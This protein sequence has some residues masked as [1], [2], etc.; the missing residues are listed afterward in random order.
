M[1]TNVSKIVF[2]LLFP[3]ALCV[4]AQSYGHKDQR[5]DEPGRNYNDAPQRKRD[6]GYGIEKTA[7]EIIDRLKRLEQTY[8]YKLRQR[9][10][11]DL[12]YQIE[13]IIRLVD[14][15]YPPKEVVEVVRPISEPNF[16]ELMNAVSSEA[17]DKNKRQVISTSSEF[18][19]FMTDQV[20]SLAGLFSFDEGKVEV[21]KILYPKILDPEKNYLLYKCVTFP[22]SKQDL[23][24]FIN[25]FN[26]DHPAKR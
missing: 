22:R 13:D 16:R 11:D 17:F 18:N 8:S 26:K 21:I 15:L 12:H 1:K 3:L 4:N 23:E 14:G 10:K 7:D 9:E 24:S 6:K 19:F 20:A 25:N 2:V 5:N